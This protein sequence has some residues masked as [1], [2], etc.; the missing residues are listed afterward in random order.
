MFLKPLSNPRQFTNMVKTLSDLD[1][2]NSKQTMS[3]I[4]KSPILM[5]QNRFGPNKTIVIFLFILFIASASLT[6]S[7]ILVNLATDQVICQSMNC[8]F[9]TPFVIG[10][11]AITASGTFV[12]LLLLIL[13]LIYRKS[14][15][16]SKLA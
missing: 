12:A 15:N 13:S 14:K 5:F 10:L 2:Q 11:L 9:V 4:F 8:I 1:T 7:I 16:S 3:Q 6:G